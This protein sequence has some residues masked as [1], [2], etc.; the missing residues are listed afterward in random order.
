MGP[1]T[2][3]PPINIGPPRLPADKMEMLAARMEDRRRA[4]GLTRAELAVKAGVGKRVVSDFENGSRAN[5]QGLDAIAQA[6]GVG[7]YW[8]LN[9]GQR[10][11]GPILAGPAGHVLR[12]TGPKQKGPSEE[13]PI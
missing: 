3:L 6:L 4:L 7:T 2:K 13:G 10:S 5:P 9:G 11:T 12:V 8:L 1:R